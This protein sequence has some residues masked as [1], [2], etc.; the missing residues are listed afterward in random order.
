MIRYLELR[1]WR[2]F[3]KVALHLN[4]GATFIVAE[5][6]IGKTTLLRGAAWALFAPKHINPKVEIRQG[7]GATEAIGVVVVATPEGD[8][9]IERTARLKGQRNPVTAT[10][11]GAAIDPNDLDTTL[12]R[13]FGVR[14]DIACQ[15]G[16]V[17]QHALINDQDLFANVARLLRH[18]TG[19]DQL[20]A[21]H[22]TLYKTK[23][24]LDDTAK[25]L[26]KTVS[27][28]TDERNALRLTVDTTRAN[29]QRLEDAE[30]ETQQQLYNAQS[31]QRAIR[32]WDHY[33]DAYANYN[34]QLTH[35]DHKIEALLNGVSFDDMSTQLTDQQQTITSTQAH[36]LAVHDLHA[37]FVDQLNTA[38]TSCPVCR[39]QLSPQ[40]LQAATSYHQDA[41]KTADQHADALQEQLAQ[42]TSRLDELRILNQQRS[43]LIP[44]ETPTV[45]RPDPTIDAAALLHSAE[46]AHRQA[47]RATALARAELEIHQ[48]QLSEA[49][50]A[51]TSKAH[52]LRTRQLEAVAT[53][54]LDVMD[55]S[56][57]H[58]LTHRIGPLEDAITNGWG[59]FFTADGRITLNE[60]GTIEL[61][62]S[63]GRRLGYEQLS[64]GQQTLATLTMRLS[65]ISAATTLNCLWVDEPLE[66]LDPL[67]RRRAANLL[68]NAAQKSG[69][70]Q[71][72]TTTYEEEIAR[73]LA[74]TNSA[75]ELRYVRSD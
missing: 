75:V 57:K 65:L 41:I 43:H 64:G 19:V 17:H 35:L 34:A 15:L 20:Q 31:L 50:D 66:H 32:D 9:E 69:T 30:E 48:R 47:Q 33:E 28:Q 56:I 68:I 70:H 18:L 46:E 61:I 39:Q 23:R 27:H 52:V 44:P 13:I 8:L 6:G 42:I 59:Q 62:Q 25:Q 7:S 67:N 24:R 38:D 2:A 29:L 74:A 58:H 37:N 16:F 73:R 45:I 3:D 40:Q 26:T 11:A 54:A 4:D 1:N 51:E 5:N 49:E 53:A 21:V 60:Q 71:I 55:R 72:L 22:A 12:A 63:N 36:Q 10:I 14:P